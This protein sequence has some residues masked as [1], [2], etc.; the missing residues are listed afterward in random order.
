MGF[1]KKWY[2][3]SLLIKFPVSVSVYL[4][5][6]RRTRERKKNNLTINT[7]MARKPKRSQEDDRKWAPSDE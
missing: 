6:I 4:F 1:H 3:I 5:A 2:A 7:V